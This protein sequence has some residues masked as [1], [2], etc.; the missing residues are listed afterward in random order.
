MT[1][2]VLITG[3]SRGIGLELTR[4]YAAADALVFAACRRPRAAEALRGLA[5]A[6]RAGSR[7]SPST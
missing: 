4:A 3:A 7:S 6:H 1:R 2:R 5:A